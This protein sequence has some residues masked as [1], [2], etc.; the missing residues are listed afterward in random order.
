MLSHIK[1]DLLCTKSKLG[2]SWREMATKLAPLADK[3]AAKLVDNRD[4]PGW[5]ELLWEEVVW[6]DDIDTKQAD[7]L[8]GMVVTRWN[9]EKHTNP[10]RLAAKR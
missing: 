4:Q 1:F 8:F 7:I 10:A 3:L 9:A 2:E 5:E 6:L